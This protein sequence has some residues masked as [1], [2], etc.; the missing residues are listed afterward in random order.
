VNAEYPLEKAIDEG[1]I[2]DYQI[3]V[4]TTP[5]DTITKQNYGGKDQDREATV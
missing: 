3:T 1:I 5:L 4:V 2:V